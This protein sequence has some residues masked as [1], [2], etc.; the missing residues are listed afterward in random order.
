MREIQ[1]YISV[2]ANINANELNVRAVVVAQLAERLLP[3]SEADCSN[4]VISK[5][6]YSTCRYVL[7][8]VENTKI[9]KKRIG[10]AH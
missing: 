9:K 2:F 1:H 4:P 10:K 5:I 7:L 3:T 6:L 8:T